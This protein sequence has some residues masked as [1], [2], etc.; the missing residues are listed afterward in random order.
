MNSEIL[1]N[2]ATLI[3]V[4]CRMV[5]EYISKKGYEQLDKLL[6]ERANQT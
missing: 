3:G 1:K 6:R 5:R 4:K 2:I